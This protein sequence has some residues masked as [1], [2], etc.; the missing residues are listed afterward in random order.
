MNHSRTL[1]VA[2]VVA[3][4]GMLAFPMAATAA[5]DLSVGVEQDPDTGEAT[6]TVADN[7]T[8]VENATVTVTSESGYAG[9]GTYET[10]ANGSVA[11][12]EPN[13]TVS[14]TVNASS[15]NVTASQQVEL[16]PREDSLAVS[17]NQSEDG[18]TT[19]TVTQYDEP[20][21]NASVEVDADSGIAGNYTTDE[22]GT[23]TLDQ[24]ED[25]VNGAIVATDGNL[26]AETG[27]ELSGAELAV[28][29]EQRDDGVF[30]TVTDGDEAVENATVEVESDGDYSGTGTYATDA[31]GEV[32]LALPTENVTID[33]TAT[34]SNETTRTS[35]DLTVDI[36]SEEPF[37]L[38]VSNFVSALQN[39]TVDGPPGQ[40][41]SEFVTGNNPGSAGDVPGQSGE[42]P[43]QSDEAAG[44]SGDAP[45]QSG[46]APGQSGD[47][48][49]QSGDDA[50]DENETADDDTEVSESDEQGAAGEEDD[51]ADSDDEGDDDSEDDDS[52]DDAPGNSGNAPGQN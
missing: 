51:D 25:D 12:P 11:L 7:E 49:G 47:A 4:V 35:A 24:P 33:V 18:S 16:V 20:A 48:P 31:D 27:I 34:D 28:T 32:A 36:D 17:A 13:E 42:A 50:D 9:N 22:N 6:V 15:D 39:A 29:A 43:G 37:G 2:A 14:V 45:G 3:L 23:V 44:E 30:V 1:T 5:A 52:E 38:T 8:A 41:I 19:V 21:E 10:D 40:V 26:T 46:D